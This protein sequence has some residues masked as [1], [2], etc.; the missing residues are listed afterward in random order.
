MLYNHGEESGYYHC[1]LRDHEP[2]G[3]PFSSSSNESVAG[4]ALPVPSPGSHCVSPGPPPEIHIHQ[5][6]QME[7]GYEAGMP[8]QKRLRVSDSWTS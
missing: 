2:S 3:G 4:D 5:V 1:L 8:L 6:H 7:A